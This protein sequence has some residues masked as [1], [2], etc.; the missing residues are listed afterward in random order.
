V[1]FQNIG[2]NSELG[3]GPYNLSPTAISQGVCTS[4]FLGYCFNRVP[5]FS[6]GTA[7][8][9]NNG[10]WTISGG[11]SPALTIPGSAFFDGSVDL[12]SGTLYNGIISNGSITDDAT[13]YAPNY[14]GPT[15]VCGSGLKLFPQNFCGIN[16]IQF[17]PASIGNIALYADGSITIGSGISVYGDSISRGD[18]SSTDN[19]FYGF[20]VSEGS[21]NIFS[22]TTTFNNINNP[23][24]FNPTPL[25]A[26]QYSSATPTT[27]EGIN[28]PI[29]LLGLTWIN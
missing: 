11:N 12:Q 25:N 1:E 5:I 27:G 10:I 23:Q 4:S 17:I 19:T 14:A 18:F 9:Y 13:V 26:S 7:F 24:T 2:G 15:N 28:E 3:T 8:S 29:G 16:G 22:G 6:S 20:I 21:N